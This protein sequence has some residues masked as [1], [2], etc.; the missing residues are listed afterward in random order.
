MT[1]L[2]LQTRSLEKQ[3]PD[4]AYVKGMPAHCKQ[5]QPQSSLALQGLQLCCKAG[6]DLMRTMHYQQSKMQVQALSDH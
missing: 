3:S 5:M 6:S 1:I 4:E 2:K